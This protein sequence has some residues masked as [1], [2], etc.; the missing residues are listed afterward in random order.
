MFSPA[1]RPLSLVAGVMLAML[2]GVTSAAAQ[3]STLSSGIEGRV[4]D[5]IGRAHV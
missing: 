1:P 2:V 3:S 5:E 4:T